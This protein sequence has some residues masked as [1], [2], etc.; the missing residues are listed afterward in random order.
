MNL[1]LRFLAANVN[2][3]VWQTRERRAKSCQC[4]WTRNRFRNICL[5][6]CLWKRAGLHSASWK[7]MVNSLMLTLP[8]SPDLHQ[9]LSNL[10]FSC[11]V[12]VLVSGCRIACIPPLMSHTW[13]NTPLLTFLSTHNPKPDYF[14]PLYLDGLEDLGL[15]FQTQWNTDCS[16]LWLWCPGSCRSPS[17]S[18]QLWGRVCLVYHIKLR[19][20]LKICGK[21]KSE[22]SERIY[23]YIYQIHFVT[24]HLQ[25]V[26][27][28]S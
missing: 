13:G 1:P 3:S 17:C 9:H 28:L 23:I 15:F 10:P 8:T 4:I 11:W 19:V 14:I 2:I 5:K 18:P 6:D 26:M 27:G 22:K 24:C 25:F 12:I 21:K 7:L 20:S 16:L